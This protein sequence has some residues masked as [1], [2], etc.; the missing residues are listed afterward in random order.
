MSDFG[1]L[2]S[3][4]I[5]SGLTFKGTWD[6][7]TNT[8][9]LTS[10][11]G[12]DGEYYIVSVGGNT[13]L[14]GITTWQV[15]DWAIF[16]GI[17]NT[18]RKVPNQYIQAY[19]TIQDEG[20]SLP[21]QKIL[22]FK[23]NI[24]TASN[25]V[26]KTIVNINE[27]SYGLFAQTANSPII[28]GTII[29]STLIDGGVGT[30]SVPANGFSIGDSFRA[31]MSGLMSAQ[32]GNTITIRLKS[33][34]TILATSGGLS[35][36]NITNQNWFLNVD[37]TIRTIGVAGVASIVTSAQFH[38]LK[39][40]SGNED[41]FGFNEVNNT[42]FNTTIPNT[43]NITAQWSSNNPTNSIYSDIFVLNK[44]F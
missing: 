16:E 20:V 30:L 34:S 39:K 38:I 43:L 27:T 33:G 42:T 26:G 11:V 22:D 19:S 1:F 40:T 37:F 5:D 18:W 21:Q 14:D 44:T 3:A 32:N 7:S 12:V 2:T 41:G 31:S 4:I 23:G 29:E 36:P 25:G 28:T 6:A 35:L 24:V 10:G 8:P 15:G 17:S 9:T 13:N